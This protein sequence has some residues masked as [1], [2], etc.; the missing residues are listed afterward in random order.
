MQLPVQYALNP[1]GID[2]GPSDQG[3]HEKKWVYYDILQ[4]GAPK[5]PLMV[6]QFHCK[7]DESVQHG[8]SQL[9]LLVYNPI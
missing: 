1:W 4:D 6:L 2:V 9:C 3:Y 5:F 8:E 7:W